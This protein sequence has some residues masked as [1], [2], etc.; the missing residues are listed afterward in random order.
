MLRSSSANF[1][2]ILMGDPGYFGVVDMKWTLCTLTVLQMDNG[3]SIFNAIVQFY[4]Y[5]RNLF[6]EINNDHLEHF[7]DCLEPFARSCFRSLSPILQL[8]VLLHW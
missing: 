7:S 6:T 4:E 3:R 5:D 1:I 2:K 8:D